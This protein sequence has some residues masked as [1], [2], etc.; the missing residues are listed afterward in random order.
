MHDEQL[1]PAQ[2][3]E[4]RYASADKMWSNNPNAA[5]VDATTALTPGRALDIGCGEG[6]DVLWLASRGWTVEGLDISETAIKRAL[7]EAHTRREPKASF[8]VG[9]LLDWSRGLD[10]AFDLVTAS[11]LHGFEGQDRSALLGRAASLVLVGGHLLVISHA[12]P[13]P[14]SSHHGHDHPLVSPQSDFGLLSHKQ[15]W[16]IEIAQVRKRPAIGPDGEEAELEDSV[17]LVRRTA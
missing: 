17:L 14:W 3:W 13:P 1:T 16:A 11:F 2:Q 10:P 5:L 8:H 15:D 6:A 9:D 7:K 12:A 4:Q